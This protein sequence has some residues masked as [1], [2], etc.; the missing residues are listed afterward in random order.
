M[1]ANLNGRTAILF[2][3]DFPDRV[4]QK[5]GILF[6]RDKLNCAESVFRA[7]LEENGNSCPLKLLRTA[8]A[9]GHA[10]EVRG[11]AVELLSAA[12]WLSAFFSAERRKTAFARMCAAMLYDRF[13]EHNLVTCCRV[14]HK[15]L[16][17]GTPEQ[18]EACAKRAVEATRIAAEV[19]LRQ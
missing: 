9:F 6:R 11:V 17:Y 18:F 7:L 2:T 5:T 3:S 1:I 13:V 15:G 12:K 16:P 10:W 19:I 4:E 14:L 8:S